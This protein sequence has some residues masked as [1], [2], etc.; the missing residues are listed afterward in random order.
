MAKKVHVNNSGQV[1]IC[2]AEKEACPYSPIRHFTD[3]TEAVEFADVENEALEH[4]KAINN[5]S[6]EHILKTLK[7]KEK[8]KA[9]ELKVLLEHIHE[10]SLYGA[11][12]QKIYELKNIKN[13][14]KLA[15]IKEV[16]NVIMPGKSIKAAHLVAEDSYNWYVWTNSSDQRDVIIYDKYGDRF[17][18]TEMDKKSKY[19]KHIEVKDLTNGAQLS[20]TLC[21]RNGTVGVQADNPAITDKIKSQL[22][23]WDPRESAYSDKVLNLTTEERQDYLLNDYLHKGAGEISFY[24]DKQKKIIRVPITKT[25]ANNNFANA[26]KILNDNK[27][28]IDV[29]VRANN[30][31]QSSAITK[32]DKDRFKKD[33]GTMFKDGIAKEKFTLDDLN[34]TLRMDSGI[35]NMAYVRSR[36][37]FPK[38][39]TQ[40]ASK[41]SNTFIRL[42]EFYLYSDEDVLDRKREYTLDDFRLFKPQLTGSIRE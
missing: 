23:D 22:D 32:E 8:S 20:A 19:I 39:Y 33:Y 30:V 6:D 12:N 37:V 28:Q 34:C 18:I 11:T 5:I 40:P 3:E 1:L 41:K 4:F 27:I 9:K 24:S 36:K 25:D 2:K 15:E 38:T 31:G 13:K 7:I 26:K 14:A 17:P 10:Q 35:G 29:T 42:G 16:L 21:S